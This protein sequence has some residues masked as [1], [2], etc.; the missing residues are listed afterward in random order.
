MVS[1]KT[2]MAVSRALQRLGADLAIWRKLRRSPLLR[3]LIAPASE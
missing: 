3:S 1:G 2:P